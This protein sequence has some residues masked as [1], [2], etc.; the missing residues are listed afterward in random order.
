MKE[1]LHNHFLADTYPPQNHMLRDLSIDVLVTGTESATIQAPVVPQTCS[2]NGVHVCGFAGD[3]GGRAGWCHRHSSGFAGLDFNL[4]FVDSHHPPC[5]VRPGI[6][7]GSRFACWSDFRCYRCRNSGGKYRYAP[8]ED[9]GGFCHDNLFT[10]A[11][12]QDEVTNEDTRTI[13]MNLY[14]FR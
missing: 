9:S 10:A 7:R 6:G 13:P 12:K 3:T 11:G 2:E 4:E 14:G 5:D 1:I 8:Q